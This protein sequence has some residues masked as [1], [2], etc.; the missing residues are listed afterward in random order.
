MVREMQ[1]EV[2]TF[3][4]VPGKMFVFGLICKFIY[5]FFSRK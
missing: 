3:I 5:M 4:L 1:Y 2:L